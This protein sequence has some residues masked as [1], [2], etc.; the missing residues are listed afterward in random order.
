MRV[1]ARTREHFA[2]NH[3]CTSSVVLA[4]PTL[5]PLAAPFRSFVYANQFSPATSERARARTKL[6]K[7]EKEKEPRVYARARIKKGRYIYIYI[8]ARGVIRSVKVHVRALQFSRE[9]A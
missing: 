8:A 5:C 1:T 2:S 4:K 7:K 9:D 3:H 6:K